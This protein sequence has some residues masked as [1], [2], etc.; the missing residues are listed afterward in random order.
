MSEHSPEIQETLDEFA[1]ELRATL[2]EFVNQPLSKNIVNELQK[3]AIRQLEDIGMT[4]IFVE[5]APARNAGEYTI[6][7]AVAEHW[8][9]GEDEED[10]ME[11]DI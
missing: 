1:A 11:W 3:A 10:E 2:D 6:N 9:F 7:F 8:L 4:P 5:V